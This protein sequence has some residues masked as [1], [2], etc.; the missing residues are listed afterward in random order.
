L[1]D[2]VDTFLSGN[3]QLKGILNAGYDRRTAFVYRA[4]ATAA[5][6]GEAIESSEA[7]GEVKRYCTWCPKAL[8]KIGRFPDTL[9]D[10]CIVIRMHRKTAGEQCERSRGLDA[11]VL[12]QQC[13]RFVSDH[14][15]E[16]ASAR[17][18]IPESLNDRAAD[19]WEP[20]LVLADLAE[21]RGR[22]WL[23]RQRS[24]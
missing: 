23:G 21:A 7:Q 5:A 1:G 13:V 19:I 16:I 24:A 20:L 4:V 8:A 12:K 10:R 22:N 6:N 2:E 15:A 14:A 3:D 18:N 9:A 17:P 11:L